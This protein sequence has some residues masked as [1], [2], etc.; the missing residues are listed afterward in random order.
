M[1]ILYCPLLF[2]ALPLINSLI[3]SQIFLYKNTK[4]KIGLEFIK[5]RLT[6]KNLFDTIYL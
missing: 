4:N 3:N 2:F 5:N 6:N 1:F